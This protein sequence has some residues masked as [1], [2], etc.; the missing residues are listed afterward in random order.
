MGET[1]SITPQDDIIAQ[2]N[3]RMLE[4]EIRSMAGHLLNMIQNRQDHPSYGYSKTLIRT[5]RDRMEGAIGL[6][7]II[8]GQAFHSSAFSQASFYEV[9]TKGRVAEA[10]AAVQGL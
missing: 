4:S 8:T 2:V 1:I 3:V 6:Y 7:M 5:Q 10:R 9:E